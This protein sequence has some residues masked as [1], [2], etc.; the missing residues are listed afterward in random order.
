[1]PYSD[2][3]KE[4][5]CKNAWA[6]KRY[7][8]DP[9]FAERSR[10]IAREKARKI[11]QDPKAVARVREMKLRHY[12]L[13]PEAKARD[14]SA[15]KARNHRQRAADDERERQRRATDQEYNESVL[16]HRRERERTWAGQR[17]SLR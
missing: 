8:S 12:E 1:M 15:H 5:V 7:A 10:Q 6:R 14:V 11:R 17:S 2:P 4:R 3:E 13:H 9:V 16:V